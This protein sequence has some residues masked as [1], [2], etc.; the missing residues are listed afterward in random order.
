MN[1]GSEENDVI[2]R[3]FAMH[4]PEVAAGTIKI[5]GIARHPSERAIVVVS[6]EQASMDSVGAC[7][8][9]R[10]ARIKPMV[11]EL[12]GEQIDIVSWEDSLERFTANL[13]APMH[14]VRVT[15]DE[16]TLQVK[17]MLARDSTPLAPEF[18]ALRAELLRLLTGWTL[19]LEMPNER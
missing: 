13:L 12:S 2:R 14:F 4:V 10:G 7:V 19:K 16:A 6:S 18:V 15:C 9:E 17:L 3:L 11:A 5:R 1:T 8:G